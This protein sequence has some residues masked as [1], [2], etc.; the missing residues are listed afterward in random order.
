MSISENLERYLKEKFGGSEPTPKELAKFIGRD[1]GKADL[2]IKSLVNSVKEYFNRNLSFAKNALFHGKYIAMQG[3]TPLVQTGGRYLGLGDMWEYEY[4]SPEDTAAYYESMLQQEMND[5]YG[6]FIQL[7]RDSS[8]RIHA[9]IN[10][11]RNNLNSIVNSVS[12][13]LQNNAQNIEDQVESTIK[14]INEE[15]KNSTYNATHDLQA[16]V[17]SLKNFLKE[18]EKWI[19]EL[20]HE[21]EKYENKTIQ[22]ALKQV[23]SVSEYV[24]GLIQEELQAHETWLQHIKRLLEGDL[25]GLAEW[26]KGFGNWFT[27][28]LLATLTKVWGQVLNELEKMGD[29]IAQGLINGVKEIDKVIMANLEDTYVKMALAMYKAQ[30]EVARKILE[31]VN[32]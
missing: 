11:A 7:E 14:Q 31:G 16:I 4:W 30:K 21:L 20:T 19:Q 9:N 6:P 25:S 26:V 15:A 32:Q 2:N 22:E 23:E 12:N 17:D 13:Y 28:V 5:A 27:N 8:G 10:N 18:H 1:V 24:K 3:V 29:Y